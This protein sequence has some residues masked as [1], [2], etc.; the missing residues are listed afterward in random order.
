M[1]KMEAIINNNAYSTIKFRDYIKLYPNCLDK[2]QMSTSKQTKQLQD[3][4]TAYFNDYEIGGETPE[5]FQQFLWDTFTK[6]YYYYQ[7][8]IDTYETKINFLDGYKS[9]KTETDNGQSRN[10]DLPHK[11]VSSEEG[12][13]TFMNKTNVSNTITKTGGANVVDQKFTYLK[14]LRNVYTEFV[15]QFKCCFLLIY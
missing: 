6:N 11:Q 10:Y 8:Y 1:I 9:T 13:L 2:L 7:E 15:E 4:F 14:R 12:Y 5:M 3:T